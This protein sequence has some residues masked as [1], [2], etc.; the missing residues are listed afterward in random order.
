M[1][2]VGLFGLDVLEVVEVDALDFDSARNSDTD[3]ELYHQICQGISADQDNPQGARLLRGF[4]GVF[5]ERRGC[6]EHT[7]LRTFADQRA[8]ET[9]D[10]WAVNRIAG[11]IPFGLQVDAVQSQAVL[12]DNT[13]HAAISGAAELLSGVCP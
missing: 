11:L 13:I 3:V 5:R 2:W 4:E 12:A 1:G 8:D 6:D 7:L 9:L 10:S